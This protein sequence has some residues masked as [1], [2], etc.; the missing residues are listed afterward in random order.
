ME[1]KGSSKIIAGKGLKNYGTKP[2][3]VFRWALIL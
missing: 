1:T 3:V 2:V